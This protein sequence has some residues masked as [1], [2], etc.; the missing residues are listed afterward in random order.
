M[1]VIPCRFGKHRAQIHQQRIKLFAFQ[2]DR[3]NQQGA[4]RRGRQGWI[5][6]QLHLEFFVGKLRPRAQC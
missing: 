4:A 1:A 3:L 2:N 5:V 6:F